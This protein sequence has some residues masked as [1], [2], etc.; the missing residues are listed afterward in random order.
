MLK[1]DRKLVVFDLETTG[2]N[3]TQDR[4]VQ[5]GGTILY[6]QDADHTHLARNFCQFIDPGVKIPNSDLHGITDEMVRGMPS[7]SAFAPSLVEVFAGADLAG[8]N[9]AGFDLLVLLRGVPPGR[10][11][12][13]IRPQWA[14]FRRRGDLQEEAPADPGRGG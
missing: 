11:R 1:I 13:R 8:F 14:N 6:P 9:I 2:T 3:P 5:V 10:A 4:I 7:F 12:A